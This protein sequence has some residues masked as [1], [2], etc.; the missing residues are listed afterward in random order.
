L[1]VEAFGLYDEQGVY[2]VLKGDYT[3]FVGGNQPD[4]R[5]EQLTG[6]KV[7]SQTITAEEVLNL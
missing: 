2:R 4:V 5:S 7:N 6:K 3:V 1:P